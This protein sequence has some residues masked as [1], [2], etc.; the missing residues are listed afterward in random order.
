MIIIQQAPFDIMAF[1]RILRGHSPKVG[2][3]ATFCGLVRDFSE[4]PDVTAIYLEHYPGMTEK[5]LNEL[6]E[7]AKQRWSII[8]AIICHRVGQLLLGEPIVYVG[9]ASA[10]RK[11]AFAA[12][13]FLIDKLKTTAP[14]WKKEITPDGEHWVDERDKD[15]K[16]SAEWG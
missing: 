14:F 1:D 2:A 6:I 16:S 9:I 7:E 10:H 12:C 5:V 8:D 4:Q 11:A 3:I 15:Q 13:E